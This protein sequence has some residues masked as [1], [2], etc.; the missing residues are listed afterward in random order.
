M[1]SS[2]AIDELDI[3]FSERNGKLLKFL[4]ILITAVYFKDRNWITKTVYCIACSMVCKIMY[5]SEFPD[6]PDKAGRKTRRRLRRTQAIAKH[7]AFQANAISI[8]TYVYNLKM[9]V[10]CLLNSTIYQVILCTVKSTWPYVLHICLTTKNIHD[11]F[12][13]NAFFSTQPQCCLT[14]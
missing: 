1:A 10:I 7:C 13:S 6:I 9:L 5:C 4:R 3:E 11:F 8:S 2:C 12:I 14:F